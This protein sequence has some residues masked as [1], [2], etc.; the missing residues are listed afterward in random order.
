VTTLYPSGLFGTS[1]AVGVDGLPLVAYYN[2][3]ESE[4]EVV[5]CSNVFCTPYYRRR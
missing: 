2:V 3:E 1:D 5:H 4:L